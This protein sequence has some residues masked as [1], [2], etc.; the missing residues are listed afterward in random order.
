MLAKLWCPRPRKNKL[1]LGESQL[2]PAFLPSGHLLLLSLWSARIRALTG[3]L[4]R[5]LVPEARPV[6]LQAYLTRSSGAVEAFQAAAKKDRVAGHLSDD[7][8]PGR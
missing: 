4:R 7:P 8:K 5:I 3:S 1:T 6:A 2:L